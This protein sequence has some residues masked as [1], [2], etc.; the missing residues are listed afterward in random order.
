MKGNTLCHK[1]KG[2]MVLD[3]E[4]HLNLS[5]EESLLSLKNQAIN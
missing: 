2:H 1:E 3:E 4:D 5:L